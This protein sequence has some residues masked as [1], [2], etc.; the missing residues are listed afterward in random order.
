MAERTVV[1]RYFAAAADAAGRTEEVFPLAADAT[2]GDLRA[3]LVERHGQG[4]ERVLGV[5][6]FL[7][8]DELTR[9]LAAAAAARVDVL[10]PFAG[11]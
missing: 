7:Q 6:A 10:P 1:V 4:M 5:A 9:D 2:L 8:D 11:G 3:V